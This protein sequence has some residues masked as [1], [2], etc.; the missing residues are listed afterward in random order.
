M[1]EQERIDRIKVTT[2]LKALAESKGIRLKKNGKGYFGLCPFH[3]DKNP[4]LSITPSKN[5]WHCF[6]CGKGGDVI[7]FVE[8][9]D[10][11][12]FK[13]A[14]HRLDSS[15]LTAKKAKA[16]VKKKQI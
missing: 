13:E 12:D 7:R 11:V 10:Q 15:S 2:D 3:H 16:T 6:G 4:S 9:Y 8:L 5:E 14:V 1:I